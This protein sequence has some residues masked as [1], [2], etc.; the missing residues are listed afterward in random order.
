MTVSSNIGLGTALLCRHTI[1]AF[2]ARKRTM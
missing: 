2:Q 1:K